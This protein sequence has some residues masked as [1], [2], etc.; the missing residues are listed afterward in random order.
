MS[1]LFFFFIIFM[2]LNFC[3]LYS[4]KWLFIHY[5][6]ERTKD[7]PK[8]PD[9]FSKYSRR[10]WDTLIKIWRIKLHEYDTNSSPE[11]Y[12]EDDGIDSDNQ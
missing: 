10:S 12:N 7:H 11:D 9:K 1:I 8:T 2:W 6:D 4:N 5:S 3:L